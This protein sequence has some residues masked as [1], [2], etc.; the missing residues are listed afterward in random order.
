MSVEAISWALKQPIQQSSAK[1]VLV[2][3][4]N[5]ADG[6]D[7]VAWPSTAYLAEATGQDRKTVMKNVALLR[8]LGVITDTG[9]RK[10]ETKQI[11]VYRLN[12]T[13]FGTV[14]QTKSS[15][16]NGTA[17]Q[18]QKRNSTENGTVPIF[19]SNGTNFPGKQSQ[20]SLETVPKTGHG[21]VKEPSEEPSGNRQY[22]QAP[23]ELPAW[24]PPETWSMWDSYRRRKSG[25]GW[26]DEA[27]KLSLKTLGK[28]RADGNDPTAVVEQSIERS[29]TGL[30]PL[31]TDRQQG[32]SRMAEGDRRIAEFL[33]EDRITYPDDG[34]TID[35]E[36]TR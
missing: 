15:T 1:F 16:K 33:A 26:T 6:K 21:T 18:S 17:K 9:E 24:M 23:L 5:C 27:R 8:D 19:P 14:K 22:A 34:M 29:Y 31:K 36:P 7:F 35:M 11:P 4:A 20:F 13:E 25:K 2:V 32:S 12:D 3:I 30:F 10:G 28:L